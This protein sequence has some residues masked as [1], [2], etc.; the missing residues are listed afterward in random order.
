MGDGTQDFTAI[1]V[2]DHVMNCTA[3][4]LMW[5]T[6]TCKLANNWQCLKEEIDTVT[7]ICFLTG[8]F[9]F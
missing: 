1:I 3:D 6:P 4:V 7:Q 8:K 5:P 2:H 9:V